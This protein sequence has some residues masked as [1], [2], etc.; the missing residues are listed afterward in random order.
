MPNTFKTSAR[1]GSVALLGDGPVRWSLKEGVRPV[2]RTVKIRPKDKPALVAEA[3]RGPLTLTIESGT[4][5]EE[6]KFLY[7]VNDPPAQN[8][9]FV[10]V[11]IADRRLWWSWVWVRRGFNIRRPVGTKRVKIEGALGFD[12]V[13][14]DVW[15]AA[16]SLNPPGPQGSP[17]KAK[18]ILERVLLGDPADPEDAG[19]FD[20]E[21][22]RDG[23]SVASLVFDDSFADIRNLD[24]EDLSLNADGATAI[25]RTLAYFPTGGVTVDINGDVRLF[26]KADGTEAE[27][28]KEASHAI[29]PGGVIRKVTNKFVRPKE[30]HVYFQRKCEIRIDF[31]EPGD[32]SPEGTGSDPL[33][34][35]RVCQNVVQ[36]PD[37]TLL[38]VKD[39]GKTFDATMGTWIS[40]ESALDAWKR[41]SNFPA[42]AGVD[43]VNFLDYDFILRSYF[44]FVD[45]WANMALAG[46]LDPDTSWTPRI[47]EVQAHFRQT[48]RINS[49]W[50]DNILQLSNE[51]VAVVDEG[52]G[53][54]ARGLI[55]ADYSVLPNMRAWLKSN[56]KTYY[57][58]PVL[59]GIDP[60]EK[61]G[62]KPPSTA[63]LRI[64][65]GDQG[66]IR[67][68]YQL[69]PMTQ[70]S[71][72]PGVF[73]AGRQPWGNLDKR[74]R[75]G[76]PTAFDSY[77]SA[78]S[79]SLGSAKL[80]KSHKITF[81]LSAV[82]ASPNNKTQLHR[83]VIT[84]NDVR[85]IIPKHVRD[86]IGD[87]VAPPM[88]VFIG[89]GVE[90]AR[91]RWDDDR[92]DDIERIFGVA[93]GRPNLDGLVVNQD[94]AAGGLASLDNLSRAT[95][96]RIYAEIADR[97]EGTMSG[98]INPKV[99]VAGRLTEVGIT[100]D[101]SGVA[102]NDLVLPPNAVKF[103]FESFLSESSRVALERLPE[104][105]S[106]TSG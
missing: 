12:E 79:K 59:S 27:M 101:P 35:A 85:N 52:S 45:L 38:G 90:Y 31:T 26:S 21:K 19:V 41:N 18:E 3:L 2:I 76:N 95:A 7:L 88:E 42:K 44:P 46:H 94:N 28:V 68:E 104:Y 102:T 54:R 51:R 92:S 71:W 43:K 72:I 91:V 106:G 17:W 93:P 13:T 9:N 53:T 40:L 74:T 37:L 24:V 99:K 4:I 66:I 48:Y 6:I 5:K 15:F 80:A 70:Q 36:V 64:V 81:L 61:I 8:P 22:E 89:P 60:T 34:D 63:Q 75:L 50:M 69:D 82:P 96:A 56:T 97:L 83:V 67:C 30:I 10:E 73:S 55:W 78:Q 84:P 58:M 16:W 1:L 29:I 49:V 23:G 47:G 77:S 65:D 32:V 62:S 14:P 11:A 20:K 86:G 57:V 103:N 100:L 105:P 39:R 87:G 33:G 98:R 25:L